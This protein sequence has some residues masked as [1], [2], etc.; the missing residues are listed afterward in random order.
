[1]PLFGTGLDFPYTKFI[2]DGG[3]GECL[4]KHMTLLS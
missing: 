4:T 1:L 3:N 2:D